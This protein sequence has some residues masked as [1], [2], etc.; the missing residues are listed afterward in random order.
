MVQGGHGALLAGLSVVVGGA[1]FL[2]LSRSTVRRLRV[3]DVPA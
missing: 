3:R 1:A 2:I